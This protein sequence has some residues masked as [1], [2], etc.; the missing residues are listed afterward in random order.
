[1][2]KERGRT[3]VKKYSEDERRAL[4]FKIEEFNTEYS[5]ALDDQDI[6]RWPSFFTDD[7]FYRVTAKENFDQGLPVGLV[8]LEGRAMFLDRVAAIENTMVFAPRYLRHYV[9]NVDVLGFNDAQEICAKA[10]YLIVE[11]LMEDSTKIFQAGIYQD[12]FVYDE[13]GCLKLKFRDCI[14]DSLLIPNDM[15]FPV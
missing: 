5:A 15:V 12:I 3:S 1:M 6:N 13:S 2:T 11:T 4:R 8:W 14:Y 10:N 7:A 9:T